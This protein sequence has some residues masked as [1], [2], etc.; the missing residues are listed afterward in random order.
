MRGRRKIA[1]ALVFAAMALSGCGSRGD[2][3]E[4]VPI[5]VSAEPTSEAASPAPADAAT[6][7]GGIC[8]EAQGAEAV[9]SFNPGFPDPTCLIVTPD[10]RLRLV[11][12][13]DEPVAVSLGSVSAILEPGSEGV[14]GPRFGDYLAPGV[15]FLEESAYEGDPEIWLR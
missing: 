5:V 10:Q 13:L 7:A 14:V 12:R 15:H 1:A 4:V 6:P 3:R 9:V 8:A 2:G 11:N